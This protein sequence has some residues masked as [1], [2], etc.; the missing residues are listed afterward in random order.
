MSINPL[1]IQNYI[2]GEFT[3]PVSG[4]WLDNYEPSTGSVYG[5]VPDSDE[6]DINIAYEHASKAFLTWSKTTAEYRSK[7]LYKIADLI[8]ERLV[9]LI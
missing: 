4:T 3:D 8:E 5:K 2:N 9:C 1:V 6:R 7:L